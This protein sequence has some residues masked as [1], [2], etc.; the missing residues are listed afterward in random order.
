[1]KQRNR[2]QNLAATVFVFERARAPFTTHCV[3]ID[4]A[5]SYTNHADWRHT[6]TLDPAAWLEWLMNHPAERAKQIES[7]CHVQTH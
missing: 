7:L 3:Y 6:A 1:M 4:Q 5:S 2:P